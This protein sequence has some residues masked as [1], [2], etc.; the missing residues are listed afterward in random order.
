MS[1]VSLRF[2]LQ[3][4]NLRSWSGL[5]SITV[6]DSSWL[7]IIR[8][9]T[10]CMFPQFFLKLSN[11]T[12]NIECNEIQRVIQCGL[13]VAWFIV[14]FG[15]LSHFLLHIFVIFNYFLFKSKIVLYCYSAFI[16]NKIIKIIKI[17][18]KKIRKSS[19]SNTINSTTLILQWM[20][21]WACIHLESI[22]PKF[23][24]KLRKHVENHLSNNKQS[25]RIKNSYR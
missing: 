23:S 22:I 18:R 3:T 24:K 25:R 1:F 15:T 11:Y 20:I 21:F 16:E 4:L 2:Q 10:F 8:E 19:K 17:L 9:V 13:R 6:F 12:L 5:L 7:L 14:W